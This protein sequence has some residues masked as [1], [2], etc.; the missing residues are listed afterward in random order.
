MFNFLRRIFGRVSQSDAGKAVIT[1]AVIVAKDR[2]ERK[3][4][5][6]DSLSDSEK[7]LVKEGIAALLIEIL[8]GGSD[9]DK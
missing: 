6:T 2:V 3:I 9:K 1:T 7:V 4:D 5:E 8:S